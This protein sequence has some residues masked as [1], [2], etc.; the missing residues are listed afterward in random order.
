MVSFSERWCCVRVGRLRGVQQVVAKVGFVVGE[1]EV[2][3]T[4]GVAPRTLGLYLAKTA[5]VMDFVL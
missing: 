1:T 3:R 5:E 4:R 2:F